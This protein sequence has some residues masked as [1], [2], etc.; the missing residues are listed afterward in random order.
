MTIGKK[1]PFRTRLRIVII[2]SLFCD[3]NTK[4]AGGCAGQNE[5]VRVGGLGDDES[6]K[7]NI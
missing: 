1:T 7:F 2:M 6:D 5:T 4:T 3:N